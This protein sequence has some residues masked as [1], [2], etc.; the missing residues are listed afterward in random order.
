[1]KL[2]KEQR[3]L[4]TLIRLDP[5]CHHQSQVYKLKEEELNIKNKFKTLNIVI[6]LYIEM[7]EK[8]KF[9]LKLT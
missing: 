9:H 2:D 4:T 6:R 7:Q 5:K 8:V 1:M 3:L